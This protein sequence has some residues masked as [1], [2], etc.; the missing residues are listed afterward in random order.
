LATLY[1][2]L[3]DFVEK[4][5][6]Q[7][8]SGNYLRTHLLDIRTEL[9]GFLAQEGPATEVQLALDDSLDGAFKL[10]KGKVGLAYN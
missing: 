7:G 6:L 2:P 10:L 1:S 9:F 3:P 8:C 4:R 5:W